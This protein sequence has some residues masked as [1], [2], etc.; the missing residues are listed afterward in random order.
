[1][2]TCSAGGRGIDIMMPFQVWAQLRRAF[3]PM[4]LVDANLLL[5][6][7]GSSTEHPA[8]ARAWHLRRRSQRPF[9]PPGEVT[10]YE[11]FKRLGLL[12]L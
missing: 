8:S 3:A 9:R 7:Y 6:A 11:Y 4:M 1:M 2:D 12:Y 10:D 5:Y